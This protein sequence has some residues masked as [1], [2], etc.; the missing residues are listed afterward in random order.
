MKKNY[1][2]TT[3]YSDCFQTYQKEDFNPKDYI[4]YKVNHSVWFGKGTFHTNTI[5]GVWSSIKRITNSFNGMNEIIY[6]KFKNNEI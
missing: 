2:A 1:P 4:L 5:E 6:N 3:I